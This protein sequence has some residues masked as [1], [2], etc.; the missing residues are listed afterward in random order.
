MTRRQWVSLLLLSSG[1]LLGALPAHAAA[2]S[3]TG[4][5]TAPPVDSSL[6]VADH[7]AQS[8]IADGI[9][10]GNI[11]LS[12]MTRQEAAEVIEQYFEEISR[13]DFTLRVGEE[14]V[15]KKVCEFGLT[16]D[17]L[18]TL[19]EAA[20]LGKS[21]LLIER[22][23]TLMD[24]KYDKVKLPLVHTIDESTVRAFVN[25]E[26]AAVFDSESIDATIKRVDGSFV[27]TDH[28]DGVATDINGTISAI[29]DKLTN[30]LS[31]EMSADIVGVVTPAKIKYEDLIV[32]KDELGAKTTAYAAGSNRGQNIALAARKINGSVVMP[33]EIFSVDETIRPYTPENGYLPDGAYKDGQVV[34]EYGGGVCQ[35]SSTLYNAVLWS[36]LTVTQRAPH[37]MVVSYLPY[38][39]DAAIAE[40]YKDLKFMNNLEHPI[41]IEA[42]TS[43]GKLTFRIFGCEYRPS[44]RKVEYIAQTLEEEYVEDK[45]IYDPN[46]LPS[47]SRTEGSRHP[48]VKATLT[49][50]VYIDGK[51]VESTLL[52]TDKYALSFKTNI[53]GTKGLVCDPATGAPLDPQPTQP[54]EPIEP[55][56]PEHPGDPTAP[57]TESNGTDIGGS[58]DH[59][60]GGGGWRP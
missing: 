24:M 14:T 19:D 49:K 41:Y 30:D 43:G 56:T 52:H 29:L 11:N 50:N 28:T 31:D 55:T 9:F 37:S 35:I 2:V 38:G 3:D 25:D 23:K 34:Q 46:L 1:L 40:G 27:V 57:P 8:V 59:P 4:A 17:V 6:P 36:E 51:L 53:V 21:G 60:I 13:S 10:I 33:G 22:Y 5:A 18:S 48:R 32:I 16:W 26:V 54:T 12:G 7:A 44:N 47:E 39:M 45:N 42:I 20:S 58:T 15:T